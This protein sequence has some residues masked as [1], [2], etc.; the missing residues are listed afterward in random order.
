MK[1]SVAMEGFLVA[2]RNM[3]AVHSQSVLTAE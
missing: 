3:P 2:R 1:D